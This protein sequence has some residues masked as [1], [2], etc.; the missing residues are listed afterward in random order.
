MVD[1]F[2]DTNRRQL[3]ILAALDRGNLFTVGD[4]LQSIYGFRHADVS[5]FRERRDELEGRGASLRLTRNFRSRAALLEVVHAVFAERFS[6]YSPLLGGRGETPGEPPAQAPAD[7]GAQPS[8]VPEA[9]L[10]L[11]DLRGW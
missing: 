10:L 1:E 6:G 4:E 8:A 11:T 3:G 2:Q 5:L 7:E 9:E